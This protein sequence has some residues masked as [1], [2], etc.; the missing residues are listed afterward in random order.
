MQ[1]QRDRMLQYSN[2]M[3]GGVGV[4]H[5]GTSQLVIIELFRSLTVET[6]S[7]N[8][9]KSVFAKAVSHF[10]HRFQTDGASPTMQPLLVSE[11]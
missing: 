6:I 2:L 4:L 1:W 8:L 3:D 7:G 5:C 9:S 10:K 11:N